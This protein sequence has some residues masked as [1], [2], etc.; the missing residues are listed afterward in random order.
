MLL[1]IYILLFVFKNRIETA[2]HYIARAPFKPGR[3]TSN[4]ARRNEDLPPAVPEEIRRS[5]SEVKNTD[6]RTRELFMMNSWT[7]A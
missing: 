6:L 7:E 4:W 1:L 5:E 2:I 3:F